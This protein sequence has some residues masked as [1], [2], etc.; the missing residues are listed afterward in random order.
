MIDVKMLNVQ[1]ISVGCTLSKS[2]Y[3]MN[4]IT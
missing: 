2:H 3:Y 1:V 4:I